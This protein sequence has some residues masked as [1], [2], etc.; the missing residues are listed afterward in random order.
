MPLLESPKMRAKR[1]WR[2]LANKYLEGAAMTPLL[3]RL[4]L[5]PNPSGWVPVATDQTD[6][7]GTQVLMA[8]V[9]V[10]NRVLPVAFHTFEYGS[11]PK[12]QNAIEGA[13][14]KL[15]VASLPP[16]CKPLFVMDRGYARVALLKEL[17]APGIPFLVRGRSKTLVRYQGKRQQLRRLGS[18][19]RRPVRYTQVLYQDDAQEPVDVVTYFDPE[20]QEP[21]YL[22]VPPGSE[23]R[24]PTAGVV[25]LYRRRMH[26]E[27]TFRDWKTHLGVRG[28]RLEQNIGVRLGRLLFVLTMACIL[29]VLLG[30]SPAATRV[31]RHSSIPR[32][33][34][35]HGTRRRLGALMVG[36]FLLSFAQYA[37]LATLT[38]A[39]ILTALA[40]GTP[41]VRL[42][43]PLPYDG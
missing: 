32:T 14:L 15:V 24:M 4:A 5:G 35:R 1:L 36:I 20:F 39:R 22:V 43:L 28:L 30:A 33:R 42:A 26:I 6:I 16:G 11:I 41:A 8:G 12:S 13:L 34:P 7:R 3:V 18:P 29:T 37:A 10:A 23:E 25:A 19:R 40:R 27:L 31:R 2:F 17:N 38:L 9:L 21:W